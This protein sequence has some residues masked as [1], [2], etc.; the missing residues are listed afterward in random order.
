M[1]GAH[2]TEIGLTEMWFGWAYH[3]VDTGDEG[4]PR[5]VGG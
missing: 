2:S 3:F 4:V 5:A 1:V